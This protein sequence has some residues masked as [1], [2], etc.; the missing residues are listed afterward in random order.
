[1]LPKD[2]SKTG[3]RRGSHEDAFPGP[4]GPLHAVFDPHDRN[5]FDSRTPSSFGKAMK[6]VEGYSLLT[7]IS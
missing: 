7:E 5:W 1:M 4:I 3:D 2:I 6:A